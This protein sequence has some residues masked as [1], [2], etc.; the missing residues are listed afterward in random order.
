MRRVMSPV[1]KVFRETL[2]EGIPGYE[3]REQQIEMALAVE[4]G[5]LQEHHVIAEAGT[6]TGK[7]FAYLVPLSHVVAGD[8]RGIVSTATIALQEQLLCKDIPFLEK[9]LGVDFRAELAKGKGN[10]L[11]LVR[12]I[13]ELQ[14]KG[15][16]PDE[17]VLERLRDWVDTTETG[18]RA[19]LPF[20]PGDTWSRVCCD[21][22]CPGRRCY[23]YDDCFLVRA[24]K[25]LQDARI[26]ICNHALFFTDLHLRECS[27][28]MAS[29]LPAYRYVVFDEA[30]H[31]E[32]AARRTMGIEVSAMRLPVLLF[33]LRKRDG[34]RLDAVQRALALNNEFFAAVASSRKGTGSNFSLPADADLRSLGGELIKAVE[35][36]VR[37][38]DP[39]LIGE[40]ENA[41]FNCLERYNR[42]L[43]EVLNAADPE[44]VYWVEITESSGRRQLV[45][46]HAT[47]LDV[48]ETLNRLLFSNGELASAVMTSATLSIGGDF[49]Y[50]R[51]STGCSGALEV[52]VDSPF[53][54]E[55]QCLLY[56]PPGLPDPRDPDFYARV[57]PVIEE[58]LLQTGGSAFVLFTSYRG[59]NEVYD[60]IAGKM[61]FRVLRQGDLPK[62][63]LIEVFKDDVQSVL[64]ATASYWEG[65]DVPGEALTCV[66]LVKLPFSVP[67]DP[68]MEARLKAIERTGRSA[69][70]S[71]SL[72]E[73]VIRL[74]QGFG[75]LIRTRQDRG[76]VAIL[77]PRVR[78]RPYG[79]IFLDVLP[80]CRTASTLEE[81]AAFLSSG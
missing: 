14:N 55:E 22:T 49:A 77:D 50:F 35:D 70:Y 80:P 71:L 7:S 66:I 10:Y 23:L 56:L 78:T 6:G 54:Y 28:G 38:F 16:F 42:D 18:D 25:R 2:P 39:D 41:I 5:L 65:V 30:Q 17:E 13:E 75:R 40:R 4:R 57:A 79:K 34:C 73:A 1:E 81:V 59:M 62:Q 26:I 43:G 44:K 8:A 29:L 15:L 60:L 48:S 52:A 31:I 72:P 61:P 63:K 67:D 58:I 3:V 76:V 51:A 45:T 21:D 74:K 33:Q 24:R 27:G 53:S 36:T 46:L 64:L 68:V 9:A 20:E 11:C 47:P 19:E 12:Y 69:F 32:Q 37:L